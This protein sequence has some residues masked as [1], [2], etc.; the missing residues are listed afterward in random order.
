MNLW[1]EVSDASDILVKRLGQLYHLLSIAW[2]LTNSGLKKIKHQASTYKTMA[3]G[4]TWFHC[5]FISIFRIYMPT[6]YGGFDWFTIL[7]TP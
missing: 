4:V 1:D 6:L 3:S 2:I 5:G 7:G